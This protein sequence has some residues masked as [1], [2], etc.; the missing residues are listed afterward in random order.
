MERLKKYCFADKLDGLHT[1]QKWMDYAPAL[2]R[3]NLC[4]SQ[5]Y[6]LNVSHWNIIERKITRENTYYANSDPLVFWHF[7]GF[8]VGAN[9]LNK[10]NT[11]GDYEFNVSE[12]I[13]EL[14]DEYGQD[15]LQSKYNFFANLHYEYS[16]NMGCKMNILTR[17]LFRVFMEDEHNEGKILKS[18]KEYISLALS[19]KV[20]SSRAKDDFGY[21]RAALKGKVG[22][23]KYVNAALRLLF[24]LIGPHYY[25]YLIR[26]FQ[27]Y[28]KVENHYFLIQK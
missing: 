22:K 8:K 6:G 17:R 20:F 2:L 23:I 28:S 13:K 4:I 10:N 24:K 15:L 9:E 16:D 19:N 27:Y 14:F 21:G 26:F 25:L 3:E 5:N 18:P 11:E 1:D 12:L 7:S